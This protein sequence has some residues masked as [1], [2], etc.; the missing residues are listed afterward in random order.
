MTQK[1]RFLSFL[2]FLPTMTSVQTQTDFSCKLSL[3]IS[4]P[5]DLDLDLDDTHAPMAWMT[6]PEYTACSCGYPV[7]DC[8][9]PTPSPY[10]TRIYEFP[11]PKTFQS[12]E[13]FY[14]STEF[15]AVEEA[16]G[17]FM[18]E[19]KDKLNTADKECPNCGLFQCSCVFDD[20]ESMYPRNYCYS[21]KG[22]CTQ[23]GCK[24]FAQVLLSHSSTASHSVSSFH[25]LQKA[26]ESMGLLPATGWDAM[27][28]QRI[29]VP[30]DKCQFPVD[31]CECEYLA[32]LCTDCVR[33][34]EMCDCIPLCQDCRFLRPH[35]ICH[36]PCSGCTLHPQYCEC[37]KL[38]DKLSDNELSDK[39]SNQEL[40][41]EELADL[42]AD[43]ELAT[44][45][46]YDW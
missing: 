28:A 21:C 40:A 31:A 8:V 46:K 45:S 15:L 12:W 24:D 4:L 26:Y 41:D 33:P 36:P 30:C 23:C 17:V 16:A 22:D 7:K 9:C 2:R 25:A 10:V 29:G 35:C 6:Q 39:L 44:K 3:S 20:Y 13:A 18:N 34:T 1:P 11:S 19:C 42:V 27:Y 43:Q 14:A 37:S 32:S 5:V 38:S